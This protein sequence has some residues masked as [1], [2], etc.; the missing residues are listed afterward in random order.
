MCSLYLLCCCRP[1]G[2]S[3]LATPLIPAPDP[4]PAGPTSGPAAPPP[5][6]DRL[7]APQGPGQLAL[8]CSQIDVW[9]RVFESGIGGSSVLCEFQLDNYSSLVIQ[10]TVYENVFY[11]LSNIVTFP[12][13][14]I[15][16]VYNNILLIYYYFWKFGITIL[17]FHIWY[18][19]NVWSTVVFLV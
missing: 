15:L 1:R 7:I 5:P 4:T 10:Y 3:D 11:Y 2:G 8:L 18:Q 9:C 19:S 17:C 13:N 16:C 6:Q 14:F 12:Y